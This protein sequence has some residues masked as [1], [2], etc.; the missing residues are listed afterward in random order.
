[1]TFV[2]GQILYKYKLIRL[3]GRGSFG[4]VWFA[5]DDAIDKKVALKILPIQFEDI[6]K[7]LEE[8]R[9]GNKFSHK[10]LLEIYYADVVKIDN[11]STILIAQ[12]YKEKGTV[13]S[14][15]NS[16]NFLPLP[17]LLQILKD[18]LL[19]LE[20]LHNGNVIHND[21][22]PS[23]ILINKNGDAV[24]ADYGISGIISSAGNP[25]IAKNSYIIHQAPE[26]IECNKINF[27]SDIYQV[28]CTAYRLANGIGELKNDFNSNTND[29]AS[30]KRR[31][32]LPSKKYRCFVPKQ[33]KTIINKSIAVDPHKRYS[34]A[35]DMRR[36]LEKINFC[37]YWTS[38]PSNLNEL[39][40]IGMK[41][42]YKYIIISKS[43]NL[44]DFKALKMNKKSTRE[45]QVSSFCKK[46]LTIKEK[47][48]LTKEYFEWVINNAN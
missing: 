35:L 21:I 46:N 29:F 45:T 44:F 11:V 38:N 30:K 24:L 14:L 5:N 43:N 6:I 23:N 19:G 47:D 37:G 39:I 4:E 36:A 2:P 33:L 1:M 13:E 15:L 31:G 28:G 9:I 48:K 40:G 32:E 12:D 7:S 27:S 34:S 3:L 18:I 10:N 22:K 16:H 42:F 26:T 25:I 41:Y 20:Y 8:A 17:I